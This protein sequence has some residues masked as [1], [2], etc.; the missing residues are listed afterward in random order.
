MKKS[1]LPLICLFSWIIG[2]SQKNIRC[3]TDE[4]IRQ[5]M[6][7]D[8]NFAKKVNEARKKVSAYKASDQNKGKPIS[9]TIP[10]V[11]HVVYNTAEEN[12]SDE[13]VQSQIDVMNE[14][15][16][17]SNSDYNNYDAGYRV[18]KG[19]LNIQYCLTQVIH[20]QT[21]H[22]NFPLNDA[23]KFT[24][25]GGSDAVDP[26]HK[27]NI[28]VC[29]IGDSYL[30]YAYL[31]G[32][33]SA[34]RFGVVCH[35]KAFGRGSQYN[36]YSEYNLGRT[37]THEIGHCFS[38]EHI[39]GDAVCGDDFVDDTPL[40]NAPNF[41]C[42]GEGHLSTCT[43]TPLE[44]WMN[45]MDYTYDKCMYFFSDGQSARADYF[46]ANDG[47]LNSIINSGCTVPVTTA[48]EFITSASSK[49]N[50]S[51]I[52]A[53]QFSIYPT[54]TSGQFVL[55]IDN[56]KAGNAEIFIFN[57]T[58]ALVMKQHVFIAE[59]NAVNN[60]NAGKLPNGAYILQLNQAGV[61]S[62]GKFIIQ[63]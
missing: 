21:K 43:G 28:W 24:K 25:R 32:T 39:W 1:F 55:S 29:D 27:L 14:D 17:A 6:A 2:Y 52:N 34:N 41:G 33:I 11:V 12:I 37:V 60:L 7:A 20:K 54:I 15:F 46:L 62:T 58:G 9:I 49:N 10:I 30:G 44:M 40:Q 47:Q 13:Q 42:P 16:T 53:K 38:L 3:A 45:Y 5:Q 48:K 4:V 8:P 23:M 22:N 61:K 63:H 35:Y 57:E 26:M 31:P 36:L 59:G 51:K 19:D 18:V 50:I 56:K